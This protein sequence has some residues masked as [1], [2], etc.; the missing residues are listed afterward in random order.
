MPKKLY[1]A[2]CNHWLNKEF[3]GSFYHKHKS[4]RK[5]RSNLVKDYQSRHHCFTKQQRLC[6]HFVQTR[7]RK[8]KKSVGCVYTDGHGLK[9]SCVQ[10]VWV[11]DCIITFSG[12]IEENPGPFTQTNNDKN[13]SFAKSV[14]SVSLLE[15][16]L[17]ELG[18]IPVNVLGLM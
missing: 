10:I 1:I 3:C 13:A 12:D 18:R 17:S 14:N 5:Q 9:C 11:A 7:T 2:S 4:A 16:R 15:S 8:H 6:L